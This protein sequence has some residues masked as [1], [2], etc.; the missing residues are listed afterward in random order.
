MW[1]SSSWRGVRYSYLVT[2]RM[3][4][5][6]FGGK[7]KKS[8]HRFSPDFWLPKNLNFSYEISYEIKNFDFEFSKLLRVA[9]YV[10]SMRVIGMNSSG[11]LGLAHD[12]ALLFYTTVLQISYE[13]HMRSHMMCHMISYELKWAHM[14]SNDIIW[15]HMTSHMRSHMSSNEIGPGYRKIWSWEMSMTFF[16][17]SW[18]C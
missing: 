4:S 3:R 11:D 2:V 15:A 18:C 16:N 6:K 5:I 14:S 1:I 12:L 17:Q 9:G 13:S 10:S 7:W 8:Q